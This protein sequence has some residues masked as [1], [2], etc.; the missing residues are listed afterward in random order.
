MKL[1][2]AAFFAVCLFVLAVPCLAQ[3][4]DPLNDKEIDALRDTNQEPEKRM[5]LIVKFA[6]ARLDSLDPAKADTKLSADDR[7][8]KLH[9]LLQDFLSI[10]DELGDNLDMFRERRSDLRKALH[11]VIQGDGE[12]QA[13]LEK[14]RRELTPD[15]Q[16]DCEF[17]LN[18]AQEAVHSGMTEHKQLLAAED[19]A[20]ASKGKKK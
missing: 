10:Y 20:F 12:F 9:D 6:R 16:K 19:E 13:R 11:E 2:L 18:N 14:V 1:R 3:H 7:M 15:E 5:K 4:S 17:V 8:Q